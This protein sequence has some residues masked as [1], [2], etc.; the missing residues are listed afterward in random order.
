MLSLTIDDGPA[1]QLPRELGAGYLIH[2]LTASLIPMAAVI[3]LKG[4]PWA[5]SP[6]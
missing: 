6:L 1:T 3:F 2:P 5:K 4:S